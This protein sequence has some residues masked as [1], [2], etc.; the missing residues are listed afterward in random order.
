MDVFII[1][2]SKNDINVAKDCSD[3]LNNFNISNKI[4]IASA[5]RAPEY[6][7]EN[8]NIAAKENVKYIIAMAGMAAH[9]PGVIASKTLIPVIG[10][11]ISSKNLN[12][13]DA[14][15]SII[16]MPSGYPVATV[17]IDAGKN[18]GLLAAQFLAVNDN[19]LKTKLEA[20]RNKMKEDILAS[21][22]E[23]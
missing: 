9:L 1:I 12:G 6:L 16:Q 15:F 17:G 10:V 14:M 4:I 19:I 22:K 2:G 23:L 5:H 13:L 20:Y 8:L 18:A 11:P 7:Q 3:I 21:N